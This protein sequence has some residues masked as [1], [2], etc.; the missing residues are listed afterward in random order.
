MAVSECPNHCIIQV[1]ANIVF[2]DGF[3]IATRSP[4]LA[5]IGLPYPKKLMEVSRK[6]L[7][8]WREIHQTVGDIGLGQD[9]Y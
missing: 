7:V 9:G 3:C 1:P 6:P 4:S 8:G 5:T 2:T